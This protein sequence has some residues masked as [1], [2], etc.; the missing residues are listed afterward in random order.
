MLESNGEFIKLFEERVAEFCGAKYGVAVDSGT[1]ALFLCFK[2]RTP[3]VPEM[4]DGYFIPCPKHTYMSVPMAIINSG[5]IPV[6]V[7]Q[8]WGGHYCFHPYGIVDMCGQF[9]KDMYLE[10]KGKLA[11]LSF[12]KKKILPI[13][14]GGMILTDDEQLAKKLRRMAF[15]GR[16]YML[17]ANE[18][19]GIIIGY[20]MNMTPDDAAKGLLEFNALMNRQWVGYSNFSSD[21]RDLT[22]MECFKEYVE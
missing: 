1:S 18:D 21:Y 8:E 19:N 13:G 15:D 9:Y 12:Q 17:G 7:D 2:E 6:F 10:H 14:K 22:E 4:P 20:H 11:C 3:R 5:N 16:D